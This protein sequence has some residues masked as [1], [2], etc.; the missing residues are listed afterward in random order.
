MKTYTVTFLP[1]G[2]TVRAA[3]GRTLLDAAKAAGIDINSIC[4]GDGVCGKCRVIAKSGKVTAHPTMFLDRHDI[5]RGVAIACQT[6][7]CG[8]V[9]VEVPPESRSGAIPTLTH[10]DAVRYGHVIHSG[11]RQ[12][13]FPVAPLVSKEFLELTPPSLDDSTPD[14]ERL[15]QA[16][17]A[18]RDIPVMQTGLAV[19]RRLPRVLRDSVWKVTAVLG[20]RGGT[21]EVVDVEP[22]NTAAGN[23]GVA[24][25]V[26]TT[27]IVAHLVNMTTSETLGNKA[28]YNSQ[29]KYG[30]DVIA[31]ILHSA[32]PGGL[33]EL[34]G[35]IIGDINGLIAALVSGAG[36]R[37]SDINSVVCAGNTTMIHLL[38]GVDPAH[39]R[40]DPYIPAA[41]NMPVIR[42]AE[43]GISIN[44]R[45]LLTALP[46]VSS[47]VG[48]DV[49]ADVLV[50]GMT[51]SEDI[52]LLIDLGT[53]GE[54]VLGNSEW[55]MCCSAS[56]GPAFEG[57]GISCG[58][59]ATAGAVEQIDLGDRGKVIGC[60]VVGGGRPLGLCGSGL[61]DTVANL[62]NTGCIDRAGRFVASECGHR[63]QTS[64]SGDKTFVLFPGQETA[65]GRDISLSEADIRNLIHTKGSIYMAANCLLEH[66][67]LSFGDIKHIYIAGGFGNH[68]KVERA[69]HI[70]LLPDLDPAVF[71]VIGNGSVEGAC[72]VLLSEHALRYVQERLAAVCNHFE[73]SASH[74]Y[75]NEYT[76]CLFLPHTDIERF[77]S[78]AR[79]SR[80]VTSKRD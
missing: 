52:S 59:R 15:Y 58:M 11:R 31:R 77:P 66:V 76:S 74:K 79:N 80:G 26:G 21:V 57:G 1:E 2:T 35:A 69:I 72:M 64:D 14:Q 67:G 60:S 61:I 46:S 6:H 55:L 50:S 41:M 71:Q 33:K 10:E 34:Q 75:M 78:A 16:L 25:D 9:V 22:G 19:L 48:G 68:L 37:L 45:G 12:S 5:Q 49:L 23:F 30:E 18:R 32:S 63:L 28:R 42:A 47:Y 24:V 3:P 7:V 13:A 51:E 36:I 27:T 53:N 73:L 39:I 8:D 43:I 44:A 4:N 70:G 29:S 20:C 62:L 56:A 40:H 17:R 38:Y 54:L 65:L